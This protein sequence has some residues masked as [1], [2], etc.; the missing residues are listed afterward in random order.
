MAGKV[1]DC[2]TSI[3]YM[4]NHKRLCS[5]IIVCCSNLLYYIIT[6]GVFDALEESYLK[7]LTFSVYKRSNPNGT[8]PSKAKAQKEQEEDILLECYNFGIAYTNGVLSLN[9]MPVTRDT[10][11]KQAGTSVSVSLLHFLTL[12]YE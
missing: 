5:L 1:N 7:S 10:L 9:G 11:K 3:Q 2:L 8:K 6:R 12:H 4:H